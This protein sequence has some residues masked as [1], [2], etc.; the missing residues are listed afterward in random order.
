MSLPFQALNLSQ[1]A[2]HSL[3]SL[4]Q[5]F[6][7]YFSRQ[8]QWLLPYR[9]RS[10]VAVLSITTQNRRRLMVNTKYHDHP[11]FPTKSYCKYFLW[12]C[13]LCDLVSEVPRQKALSQLLGKRT[14]MLIE[15]FVLNAV[16]LVEK[17]LFFPDFPFLPLQCNVTDING[18]GNCFSC[19]SA[20]QSCLK[21]LFT[22]SLKSRQDIFLLRMNV[23]DE[24]QLLCDSQPEGSRPHTLSCLWLPFDNLLG[25]K[26]PKHIQTQSYRLSL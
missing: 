19:F 8:R 5:S 14:R 23:K 1:M 6:M 16:V 13:L 15:N 9:H 18:L 11:C 20:S 26:T 21:K 17:W 12:D 22:Q 25:K 4:D 2:S 24:W 3:I 10:S 7:Q